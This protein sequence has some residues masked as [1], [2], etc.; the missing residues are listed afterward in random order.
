MLR[1]VKKG[2]REGWE[3]V[4]RQWDGRDSENLLGLNWSLQ[5]EVLMCLKPTFSGGSPAPFCCPWANGLSLTLS[6]YF[7]V[8]V[9][10]NTLTKSSFW[11]VIQD[12]LHRSQDGGS[13]QQLVTWHSQ[14]GSWVQW[15][16]MLSSCPSFH[17]VQGLPPRN[18]PTDKMALPTAVNGIKVIPKARESLNLG[19]L[20]K[21]C[22]WGDFVLFI[23]VN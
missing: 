15:I 21:A 14:S 18:G 13:L 22:L 19:N 11:S 4:S 7:P 2:R 17:I 8:V 16:P 5:R 9:I 23:V 6:A 12:F 10:K 20:S 1:P 3:T